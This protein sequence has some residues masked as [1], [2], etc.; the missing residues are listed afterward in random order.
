M[1]FKIKLLL[2]LSI[3]AL[4]T[5]LFFALNGK[6][7]F[8]MLSLTT[9]TVFEYF[10]KNQETGWN[11]KY[12]KLFHKI[13][14]QNSKEFLLLI[15]QLL[16]FIALTSSAATSKTV[17]I[18]Y[19]F[20]VF[21]SQACC[22]IYKKILVPRVLNNWI[23]TW[24]LS[25]NHKWMNLPLIRHEKNTIIFLTHLEL[26]LYIGFVTALT[27]GSQF[28]LY[29]MLFQSV[30]LSVVL[31]S[32]TAAT[33]IMHQKKEAN[34]E[35]VKKAIDEY[36]P[37]IYFFFNGPIDYFYQI[38]QWVKPLKEL[39][40]KILFIT[41]SKK[42]IEPVL[43]K[44]NFPTIS[45][46]YHQD[47]DILQDRSATCIYVNSSII[48]HHMLKL[49]NH[50]HVLLLHGES[51]KVSS[52]SPHASYYDYLFVSG[53]AAI[54]RYIHNGIN[55]PQN[56]FRI[57]GRPQTDCIKITNKQNQIKTLLYA[58]TWEGETELANY[59]SVKNMA[60]PMLNWVNNNQPNVKIIFKPHPL[61]TD[62]KKIIDHINSINE[63]SKIRHEVVLPGSAKNLID[64]FNESD[65]LITDIS[66]VLADFLRSEKPFIVTDPSGL[67]EDE[68]TTNNLTT[69]GGYIL[70]KNISNIEKI[71]NNIINRN[72]PL[73]VTR[74]EN[75]SY[76]LGEF[77]GSSTD[78]FIMEIKTILERNCQTEQGL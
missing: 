53:K 51:D 30:L 70:D 52:F 16:F 17:L 14:I 31:M 13:I 62:S 1:S 77:T 15:K 66:G 18:L 76:I 42:I 68:M 44:T 12:S 9:L 39:K 25:S 34:K 47:M 67:G 48:N 57:I 71:F 8:S 72:D 26:L 54:D 3:T 46:K 4:S 65:L 73:H 37:D 11:N 23:K 28:F 75:K 27:L 60:I 35:N 74:K 7:L 5:S 45:L 24:K 33:F 63:K 55:I 61:S 78:R 43:E 36:N 20:T 29:T 56:K 59:S 40:N 58:P 41:K 21:M 49:Q 22:L 2:F 6:I 19:V 64:C 32:L 10:L 50:K 38:E 69:R